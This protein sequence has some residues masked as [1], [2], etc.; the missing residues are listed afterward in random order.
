[1]P[2]TTNSDRQRIIRLLI[3]RVDVVV[4][5]T[6]EQVDVALNWSGGFSS[7]HGLIR[8]VRRY[9]QTADY[10]R[11]KSRIVELVTA[12]RSYAEI[13]RILNE[14]GFHPTKQT[15]R[16]NKSIVGRLAK[17]F[18]GETEATRKRAPIELGQHEWTVGDLSSELQ[19]PRTTLHSWKQR[20]W[21]HVARQLPGY[22]GQL[23]YW[24]D[25]RELSRLR[26]SRAT[27]WN[28][29]DPPLPAEL[30]TPQIENRK[31]S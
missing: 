13:A 28:Y 3:E 8:P 1:M 14:D 29:G 27:K 6:T 15:N 19:I 11:L 23:I 26:Q 21:L 31:K 9:E 5:G 24:A 10:E 22:R 30:T 16:F 12:G 25:N 2:S 18:R 20:G 17:K 7:H 4:E